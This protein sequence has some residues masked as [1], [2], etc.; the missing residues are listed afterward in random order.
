MRKKSKKSMGLV[1]ILM[2]E[3]IIPQWIEKGREEGW[4]KGREETRIETA[5]NAL[6]E[7]LTVEFVSRITGLDPVTVKSFAVR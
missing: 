4:E 7:G 2:E 6:A 5:K 1:E 3:G